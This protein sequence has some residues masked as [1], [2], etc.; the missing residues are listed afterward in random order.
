MRKWIIQK[1][2]KQND[3]ILKGSEM[4]GSKLKNNMADIMAD[5]EDTK[6]L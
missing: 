2:I 5:K 6:P 1:R 3:T 4:I